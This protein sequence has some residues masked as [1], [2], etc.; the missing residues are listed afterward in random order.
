MCRRRIN[1]WNKNKYSLKV[2][3]LKMQGSRILLYLKK[4][5]NNKLTMK[6]RFKLK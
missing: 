6:K 4:R 1:K 2:K 5:K 3:F